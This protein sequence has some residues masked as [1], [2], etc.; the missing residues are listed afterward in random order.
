MFEE[1]FKNID[2]SYKHFERNIIS[3]SQLAKND[4]IY[5]WTE[6]DVVTKL[7]SGKLVYFN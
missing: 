2:R 4:F 6:E 1:V 7:L 3:F 5:K